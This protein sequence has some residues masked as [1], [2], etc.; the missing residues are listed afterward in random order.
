MLQDKVFN[1]E[2]RFDWKPVALVAVGLI[3]GWLVLQ[4]LNRGWVY[5]A[6]VLAVLFLP[7][8]GLNSYR[9]WLLLLFAS[10]IGFYR[11]DIGGVTL[12]FDQLT[13]LIV[14]LA[15]IPGLLVGRNR[16]YGVPLLIP[17]AG[18]ITVNFLSSALY[19]PDKMAG[20]R[21]SVLLLIYVLMYVFSAM[22]LQGQG[23]RLKGAVKVLLLLGFL[24]A[25]YAMIALAANFGG[26]WLGGIRFGHV[27][28]AASLMGAFQE[29]NLF[30]AFAAAVSL[31]YIALLAGGKG[32]IDSKKAGIGLILVLM[33]L[34]LSYT[35]AAWVGFMV[36]MVLLI[37]IQ[38]PPRNLFN[39]RTAA[40]VV[41]L[42]L[43]LLFVVIPLENTI[44]S[45]TVSTRISE[46][47]NFSGGSAEGRVEV[48][49][50]A[51]ERWKYAILLGNGTLTLPPV[52]PAGSWIYSSV[53]QALHD[54]GL[55]G[56][57]FLLWFQV[58][59]IIIVLR[60]YRQTQDPFYR[61]ALAGFACG[62]IAINIASQ[63]SSFL[64]LGFPWIYAGLA[65]AMARTAAGKNAQGLSVSG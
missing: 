24:Q 31:M 12:R 62:S 44:S 14:F 58:G 42:V 36:G 28:S 17:A 39:P 15:W 38:K 32:V 27:E 3:S 6:V 54:T 48:Q 43:V 59:V 37:F 30:A 18:Y 56:V 53:L 55:F 25:A 21:G 16:L 51:I 57:L 8:I 33:A 50:T 46:T 26:V 40:I 29:P 35:R 41:M 11:Y 47:F 60:S 34:I 13:L 20:Y 5:A 1:L 19:A 45:G 10:M 23:Q 61:A 2:K 4:L 65:I 22:V 7:L 49:R 9:A 64:W 52:P 63:A